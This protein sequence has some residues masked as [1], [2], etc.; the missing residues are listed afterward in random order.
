MPLTHEV[1]AQR[2]IRLQ[3]CDSFMTIIIKLAPRKV[4]VAEAKFS[5][6]RLV[7]EPASL[8]LPAFFVVDHQ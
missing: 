5:I 4:R 1:H 2:H 3:V 8:R 6:D 7:A